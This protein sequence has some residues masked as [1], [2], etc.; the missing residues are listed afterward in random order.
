M[1]NT[2]QPPIMPPAETPPV[3]GPVREAPDMPPPEPPGSTLPTAA[4]KFHLP[5]WAPI[6]GVAFVLI[7]G[8]V[9]FANRR[10]PAQVVAPTPTPTATQ[11]A[12]S[13]R[14]LAPLATESAFL[15]FESDLEALS[16][17]IQNTQVQNQ[18][19]VPPRLDLPLG[20]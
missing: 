12:I 7:L 19:L 10:A 9:W 20:F 2:P 1:D 4:K 6:A 8:L 14:A 13:N 18:Q 5:R 11:S 16:R 3:Y 15:K 17:G